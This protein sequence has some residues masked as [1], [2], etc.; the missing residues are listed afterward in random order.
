MVAERL[1][2]GAVLRRADRH[3]AGASR[4]DRPPRDLGEV[5]G[6]PSLRRPPRRQVQHQAGRRHVGQGAAG[7]GPVGLVAGDDESGGRDVGAECR[8][9]AQHPVDRVRLVDRPGRGHAMRVEP[10][11]PLAG[12]G[13][14]DAD[15]RPRGGGH[16]PR[17]E[18][19]LQVD[20]H[21]EPPRPQAR[22]EP[23]DRRRAA[24]ARAH[25]LAV[26][27]DHLVELGVAVEQAAQRAVD[28][29]RD[30]RVG[31]EAAQSRQDRQR[32][33]HV[34]QRARLDQADAPRAEVAQPVDPPGIPDPGG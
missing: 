10:G 9:Q 16:D 12:V 20:R 13:Q 1:D 24:E 32:V 17:A 4:R 27:G 18:Q 7:P 31:P 21:V 34:A 3:Q 23:D 14:P 8:G 22:Q 6:G 11:A 5:L 29:P 19:P 2:Q 25:A 15:R 30:L 28:H 26:E 33:D